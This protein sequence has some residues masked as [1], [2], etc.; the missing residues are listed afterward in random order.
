MYRMGQTDIEAVAQALS[1]LRGAT[2]AITEAQGPMGTQA[3][4]RAFNSA[5]RDVGKTLRKYNPTFKPEKFL[6][7][8]GM[9]SP[10]HGE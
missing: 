8:C 6:R 1:D 4:H 10:R 2:L 7:S 5:C 3:L 9:D